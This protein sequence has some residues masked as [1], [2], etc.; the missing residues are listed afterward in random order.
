MR[1]SIVHVL[2]LG[3]T[4]EASLL[5][6]RIAKSDDVDGVLSLAGRT[7]QPA[8]APIPCRIGGF[9]GVDGLTDYL[10]KQRIDAVVDATHPFA[11][12]MSANAEAACRLLQVPLVAFTRPPWA[13]TAG[14]RWIA[15]ADAAAAVAALGSAPRRVFLSVGSLSI[16][17]FAAAPQHFYVVRAID[18]PEAIGRLPSHRL[19]LAR[20]PFL[21]ED[22]EAL[23]R[24]GRIDIIVSKN[25]GGSATYAKIEAA[26]RLGVRV[27]MVARPKPA[28]VAALQDVE[29]V[30]RWLRAQRP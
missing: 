27:V 16:G 25:S 13:Q 15:V 17:A 14:D 10:R 23:L 28:E 30:L 24:E 19:I 8:P 2:I 12:Q 21:L 9:G 7:K 18:A 5:A 26:R 11:A 29:E 3:G 4:T 6:E 1:S 20:G 22:E